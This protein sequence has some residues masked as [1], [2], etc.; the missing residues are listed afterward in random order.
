MNLIW[1]VGTDQKSAQFYGSLSITSNI[2]SEHYFSFFA[3]Q[4]SPKNEWTV[5]ILQHVF[6][7][8]TFFHDTKRNF[9]TRERDVVEKFQ[10]Y[11]PRRRVTNVDKGKGGKNAGVPSSNY[12]DN[13]KMAPTS[14]VLTPICSGIVVSQTVESKSSRK[15][16]RIGKGQRVESGPFELGRS[17]EKGCSGPP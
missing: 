16:T 2:H 17:E 4:K 10:G 12:F 6:I 15:K 3:K 14:S 8:S 11:S 1:N 5:K 9:S 13:S 7:R